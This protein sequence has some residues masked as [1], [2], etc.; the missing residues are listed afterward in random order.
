MIKEWMRVFRLKA[1]IRH[2]TGGAKKA[3][4][5][6]SLISLIASSEKEAEPAWFPLKVSGDLS[7]SRLDMSSWLDAPAGKWGF[8]KMVGQ[9]F[10][11]ENGKPVK[12]WGV[13]IASGWSFPEKREAEQWTDYLAH[14]GLN[15][16]RFHKFTAPGM[17][18]NLST[19]LAADK[20]DKLDYFSAKLREKGIYYGWSHIYGHKPLAGDSSRMLAYGEV[21]Q[22]GNGH[23]KGSTI[24]LVNFAPDLQ[25]L[26]IELTVNMLNHRN[27]YT[28]MRYA[29]DPALNFIELQN[30]DNLFF[31][32]AHIW[33]MAAPSYK[34]LISQQFSEWLLEKYKTE[35]NFLKAWG[36]STINAWPE[37]QDQESLTAKNIYPLAHHGYLS[38][39]SFINN[40][41]LQ[42]RL[43]DTAVFLY[44]TQNKFYNRYVE[45]IRKTGY[46]GPIVA[47]GWQAGD[48][49]AHYLNLHSDYL[50]G[51]I[52][53]HN[54]F[55]GGK[56]HKLDTGKFDNTAMVS[57]PG[58]GLLSTGMQ[59]VADRPF[60]L[61]E[62]MSLTPT[63]WIAE[64]SPIVAIYGMGLQGW[65]ASYAYASNQP[66]ITNTLEAPRHG[67]YNFDSPLYMPLSPALARMVY[68]GDVSEGAVV[69][70]RKVYLPDL[71]EGKLG[72]TEKIIQSRDI[73]SFE[74]TPQEALA[75]GKVV[76]EFTKEAQEST[77]PSLSSLYD[78]S[79]DSTIT[80]TTGE[81]K[82]SKANKGYFSVNT[83][84]TK[85]LVGFAANKRV[86]LG[87]ITLQTTN[88]FAVVLLT[89]LE[90]DKKLDKSRS[91]LV[92][93][94]ARAK[95]EGMEYDKEK[96]ALLSIG[97]GPVL[98][99]AVQAE[100]QFRGRKP[101]FAYVLD[102]DG[103]RTTQK[104]MPKGNKIMLNGAKHKA[105]YYE[106]VF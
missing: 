59:A 10:A 5:V 31:A 61:S 33:I 83:A 55:G 76:I 60:A 68:R 19:Q 65:D 4:L 96:Q 3:V 102:H 85:G 70:S 12:F 23:L 34:K 106:I 87:N 51:I 46:K 104:I 9:D 47:S 39:E 66:G 53:R 62:W 52:D 74:G 15:S 82:W 43:L 37:F 2:I 57:H 48:F 7:G 94:I 18:K 105:F 41:H 72:F 92:T 29:E 81:L 88:P 95:N 21:K 50:A 100:I 25:D 20:F 24:G 99:E 40:P 97:T 69:A 67:V 35:E 16:V 32:T 103:K 78:K 26:S 27:P 54:Y 91:W 89:A 11:F 1:A 38:R 63:E 22:V 49:V 73:K 98:M 64:S 58:S 17:S 80:A 75:K 84:G 93:T 56:G 36:K 86:S 30:E 8:V 13:N 71:A 45:A 44:E 77:I 14:W 6:V 28:G 79:A 42:K 90:K 101:K